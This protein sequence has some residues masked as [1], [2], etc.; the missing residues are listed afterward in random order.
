MSKIVGGKPY[1]FSTA[2][3]MPPDAQAAETVARAREKWGKRKERWGL[4]W[5][6]LWGG[7]VQEEVQGRQSEMGG[8]FAAVAAGHRQPSGSRFRTPCS[9]SGSHRVAP[10]PAASRGTADMAGRAVA[11]EGADR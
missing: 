3:R 5:G 2:E 9:R 11:A 6:V 8:G 4:A 10:P 1:L 7:L